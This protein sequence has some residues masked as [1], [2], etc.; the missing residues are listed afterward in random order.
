M[1]VWPPPSHCAWANKH[2]SGAAAADMSIYA[3]TPD[4]KV[5]PDKLDAI[6]M[7]PASD[8]SIDRSA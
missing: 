4:V 6:E 7:K 1:Y 8:R 5:A 3:D 2:T